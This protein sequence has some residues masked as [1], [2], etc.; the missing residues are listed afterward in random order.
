M[1]DIEG[2]LK[3]IAE[4]NEKYTITEKSSEADKLIAKMHEK[5]HTKEEFFLM[6]EEVS[7]FL[8]SDASEADKQK[9]LGY[10]E[11]LSMLCAAIREGRLNMDEK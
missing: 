10:T 5:K 7:A 8:K 11:S 2:L 4:Y 1:V 3:D 9:V 6:E